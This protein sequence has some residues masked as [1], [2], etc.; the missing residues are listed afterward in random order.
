MGRAAER[1]WGPPAFASPPPHAYIAA[2]LGQQ[3]V[4]MTIKACLPCNL[5]CSVMN[6]FMTNIIA[7]ASN[8]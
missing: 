1:K 4:L 8:N 3:L 5:Q 6:K 7:A 2:L